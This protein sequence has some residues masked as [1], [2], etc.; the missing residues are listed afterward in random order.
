MESLNGISPDL[1]PVPLAWYKRYAMNMR[2]EL[3]RPIVGVRYL[4]VAGITL[5]ILFIFAY[6]FRN[7]C[8]GAAGPG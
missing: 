4:E 2:R 5:V 6:L 3:Q 7:G 1:H 8:Y